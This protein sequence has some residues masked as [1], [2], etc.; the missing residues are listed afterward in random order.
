MALHRRRGDGAM[1]MLHHGDQQVGLETTQSPPLGLGKQCSPP[2]ISQ[3]TG[4]ESIGDTLGEAAG[5][6]GLPGSGGGILV[7]R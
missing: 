4:L 2:G 7:L 6:I 5:N 3:H 1:A